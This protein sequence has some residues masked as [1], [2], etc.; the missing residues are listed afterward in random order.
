M[1]R[2]RKICGLE[3]RLNA[4]LIE[5]VVENALIS[6]GLVRDRFLDHVTEFLRATIDSKINIGVE[7]AK[8]LKKYQDK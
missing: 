1:D 5:C 4:R 2:T 3:T 7:N 6:Q 8:K